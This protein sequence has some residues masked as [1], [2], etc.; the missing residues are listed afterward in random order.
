[1]EIEVSIL[2]TENYDSAMTRFYKQ[3]YSLA[4]TVL[5]IHRLVTV[6][7]FGNNTDSSITADNQDPNGKMI[8]MGIMTTQPFMEDIH[9]MTCD[10]SRQKCYGQEI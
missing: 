1:M 4:S 6:Y 2:S 5:Y 8:L 10:P 9:T 3:F 7:N